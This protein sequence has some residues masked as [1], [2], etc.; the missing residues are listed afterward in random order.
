MRLQGTHFFSTQR[1]PLTSG[2]VA[3]EQGIFTH[4]DQPQHFGPKQL[5]NLAD[6]PLATLAQHHPHPC[7]ALTGIQH[8]YPSRCGALAL[9]H[10]AFTPLPQRVRVGHRIQQRPVLF[11]Y[12]EARVRQLMCQFAIVGQQDQPFAI[13]VQATD[14]KQAGLRFHQFNHGGPTVGILYRRDNANGFVEQYVGTLGGLTD[15]CAIHRN[16]INIRVNPRTLFLHHTAID[17]N[18]TV[19]NQLFAIAPRRDSSTRQHFL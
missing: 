17:G 13:G 4:P 2:Q 3:Q 12:F 8:F 6:L 15:L 16:H 1:A 7:A 18:A 9:Q 11:F 10:H 14:R 19:G 5:R